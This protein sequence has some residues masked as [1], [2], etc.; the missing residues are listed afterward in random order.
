MGLG[1]TRATPKTRQTTKYPVLQAKDLDNTMLEPN[2][3]VKEMTQG[4]IKSQGRGPR[5]EECKFC[6]V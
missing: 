5:R 6:S 4:D 3:M 1:T 2:D